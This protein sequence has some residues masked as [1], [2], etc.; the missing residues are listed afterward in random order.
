MKANLKPWFDAEIISALQKR[1]KLQ[2]TK[3][4]SQKRTKIVLKLPKY[5]FKRRCKGEKSFYLEKTL[6]NFED[7]G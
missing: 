4:Q 5:S 1:K 2:R 6:E 3:S 7:F